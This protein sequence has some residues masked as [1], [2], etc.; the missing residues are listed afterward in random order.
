[1]EQTSPLCQKTVQE[2]ALSLGSVGSATRCQDDELVVSASSGNDAAFAELLGRHRRMV[3]RTVRRYF[4][5]QDEVE[6]LVQISFVEAWV[7]IGSYRG[8]GPHS[9]AAWLTRIAINSCYD[10][11][12]RRK[13]SKEDL[14]SQMG[15]TEEPA[16][17]DQ[18]LTGDRVEQGVIVRNLASALL[19]AL[20]PADRLAFV[21]LKAGEF[22]IA[23]IAQVVGWSETKV[24]MRIHRAKSILRRKLR[25]LG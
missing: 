10:E 8:R 9:F 19:A 20:E 22:S 23:E 25:R 16:L 21:M 5:R 6:E 17:F 24:K 14:I 11:L 2:L 18:Q 1:M 7:A 12:R 4:Q 13:R 3:A 15:E